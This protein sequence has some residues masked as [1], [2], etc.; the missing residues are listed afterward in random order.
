MP[1]AGKLADNVI[2]DFE[3]WIAGGAPDPRPESTQ[4]G[5]AA[6]GARTID[7]AKGR[8]WW[9]FQPVREHEAPAMKERAWARTKLDSFILSRLESNGLKPS[10]EADAR[11]L[12][13]RLYVDLLG[14][15]P[16]YQEIEAYAADTSPDRYP[17]LVKRL[18]AAPQYG[19]RWSRYWLD[20][21]RYARGRTRGRAVYLRMAFSRLGDQRPE[22]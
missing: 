19:E 6:G 21:T 5:A 22:Q 13:S 15:K 9:S 1:P 18:L 17:K 20:V 4:P 3:Q 11:T 12:V 10:P 2:R 7:L 8:Q 14:Y 16:T